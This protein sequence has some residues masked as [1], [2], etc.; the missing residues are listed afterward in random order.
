MAVL[1]SR[2]ALP[3]A[4]AAL[5]L[6]LRG[7][8]TL[9]ALQLLFVRLSSGAKGDPRAAL[10]SSVEWVDACAELVDFHCPEAPKA[11][12]P[13]VLWNCVVDHRRDATASEACATAVLQ[14]ELEL[15]KQ[16]L[17]VD[18]VVC[19]T[20]AAILR[21]G[22]R[23][24]DCLVDAMQK[25]ADVSCQ[26]QV[27]RY[28]REFSD[29]YEIAGPAL[30]DACGADRA[31][32]CKNADDK[33]G[34]VH[35][36][37][38]AH[39][40]RLSS[41]CKDRV[42]A[43]ARLW[44]EDVS[45]DIPTQVS[46][47]ADIANLCS[48]EEKVGGMVQNCL[49]KASRQ[50]ARRERAQQAGGPGAGGGVV[51]SA[52]RNSLRTTQ[53]LHSKMGGDISVFPL[54]RRS[55]ESELARLCK[56]G[57][58][59]LGCLIQNL[60]RI[61]EPSCSQA[62]REFAR[63][64]PEELPALDGVDLHVCVKDQALLC[65]DVAK[66]AQD[67]DAN[68]N[69]MIQACLKENYGKLEDNAC[70]SEIHKL[71]VLQHETLD[72][73][74]L[75]SDCAAELEGVCADA[76][77]RKDP[78]N[79]VNTGFGPVLCLVRHRDDV[80]TVSDTCRKAIIE[81]EVEEREGFSLLPA[82]VQDACSALVEVAC[83]PAVREEGSHA[84]AREVDGLRLA[85]LRNLFSHDDPRFQHAKNKECYRGLTEL[86]A[87]EALDL[88]VDRRKRDACSSDVQRLC[89]EVPY[90]GGRLNQCLFDHV[91]KLSTACNRVMTQL[92][93]EEIMA[94]DVLPVVQDACHTQLRQYCR[95]V[96]PGEGRLFEC[97]VKKRTGK[98]FDNRCQ[99]ALFSQ[100]V[101]ASEDVRFN[102]PLYKSCQES[103][104]RLCADA[105]PA[106][107]WRW[108]NDD[109]SVASAGDSTNDGSDTG[110]LAD[111]HGKVLNCLIR[112]RDQITSFAREPGNRR[113]EAKFAQATQCRSH[114]AEAMKQ[115]ASDLRLNPEL[116][117]SCFDDQKYF[118]A[119]IKPGMG[120][121]HAC[122]RAHLNLLKPECRRGE[123]EE[124]E[125]EASDFDLKLQL[126]QACAYEVGAFCKGVS[127]KKLTH[128][129]QDHTSAMGMSEDCREMIL[130]DEVFE[131]RYSS[132]NPELRTACADDPVA[133]SCGLGSSEAQLSAYAC[134]KDSIDNIKL[135]A[136]KVEV[137]R[138]ME[139]QAED[140]RLDPEVSTACLD[141]QV[142]LCKGVP[143]G[144]GRIHDCLQRNFKYLDSRCFEEEFSEAVRGALASN[145][146]MKRTLKDAC[147]AELRTLCRQFKAGPVQLACLVDL[148]STQKSADCRDELSAYQRQVAEYSQLDTQLQSSC[149][150][151]I[152]N[153]CTDAVKGV[154]QT[155]TGA[156]K[157]AAVSE[158]T[159]ECLQA[160]RLTM[161]HQSDCREY[162]LQKLI[163]AGK[164]I[165]LDRQLYVPCCG[166]LLWLVHALRTRRTVTQCERECCCP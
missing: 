65:T 136:C 25:I 78:S 149:R 166:L 115:I 95:D 112:R 15:S 27:R 58:E 148:P 75:A 55:C 129:L 161:S 128:C 2:G 98:A 81:Y 71:M 11:S 105:L 84:A 163:E 50:A 43:I 140:I 39:Y 108:M 67:S 5:P 40:A 35:Q 79:G 70:K 157:A 96:E 110:G 125:I 124:M 89:A 106:D 83:V 74:P 116:H 117:E 37:L 59:S 17:F 139:K 154:D 152:P 126:K 6:V 141:D 92:M 24:A 33:E 143:P 9:L 64:Q 49:Q 90:Q 12:D 30:K 3:A 137:Q 87:E 82:K 44:A 23:D 120:S 119:S 32:L 133:N 111:L 18:P 76:A 16:G 72:F 36:C 156:K 164:D 10:V 114:V 47:A 100:Q 26:Q 77:G 146:Q 85:C 99:A 113:Q 54:V 145:L 28:V 94:L 130:S 123:F 160:S 52:C 165:Q 60:P 109:N 155:L 131:F 34:G 46:C 93:H 118:C 101:L 127:H 38:Q 121:V 8:F 107:G 132:L 41:D 20:S 102:A 19:Q 62:L 31:A 138:I 7:V 158:A 104:P 14:S 4:A 63:V 69:P 142:D 61:K 103:I 48:S 135:D 151:E 13:A 86:I 147:E 1:L 45:L 57:T 73:N 91:D 153:F 66:G 42:I 159:I 150:R 122:L 97:L 88:N 51:S 68:S 144:H 56:P 134:L 162:L 22:S 53:R 29:V 21:C 80:D